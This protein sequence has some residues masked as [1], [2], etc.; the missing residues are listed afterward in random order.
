MIQINFMRDRGI[1]NSSGIKLFILFNNQIYIYIY[2]LH[3]KLIFGNILINLNTLEIT[4][5]RI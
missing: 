3:K 4:R 2:I 5:G 1:F